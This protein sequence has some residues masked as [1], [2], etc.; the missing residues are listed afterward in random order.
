MLGFKEFILKEDGEAVTSSGDAVRGLGDVS[1]NPA[2]QTSPLQQYLATN[3]LAKDQQNGAVL[4]MM[5]DSQLKYN[6]VG[7]KSFNPLTRD[8]T[9]SYYDRDPNAELLLRDRLRNKDKDN[10]A[11]RG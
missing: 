1:G 8:K 6:T 4:R 3:A 7:F 2:V 11:T 10:N 5:K 9:L